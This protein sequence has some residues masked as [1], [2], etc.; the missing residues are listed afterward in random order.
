MRRYGERQE[1]SGFSIVAYPRLI[2]RAAL[3]V[4]VLTASLAIDFVTK[5]LVLN[6]VM[7]PPRTI[8]ITRLFNLGIG[9]NAGVSF[10]MFDD[11]F[12]RRPL[13]LAGMTGMI[14]AT[15]VVL[16]VRTTK[17][18]ETVAFGMI[19]GG[20]AGNVVDRVRQGAVTDFLDFHVGNWH[21]RAFNTADVMIVVGVALMISGSIWPGR[22][23]IPVKERPV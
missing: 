6:V 13:L 8:E 5:L 12:V 4:G 2:R 21:W 19:A 22:S 7:V 3:A 15:L 17:R 9:F 10:G 23:K 18:I 16:A 20:A 14:A 1:E 11:L